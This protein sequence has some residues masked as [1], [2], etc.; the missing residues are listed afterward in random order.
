MEMKTQ[1]QSLNAHLG[2][3]RMRA[4]GNFEKADPEANCEGRKGH[5]LTLLIKGTKVDLCPVYLAAENNSG[6]FL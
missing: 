5:G 1:M 3:L 2:L 6:W 4:W